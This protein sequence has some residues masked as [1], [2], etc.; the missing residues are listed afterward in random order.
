[1]KSLAR[2]LFE[3]QL[4]QVSDDSVTVATE[5]TSDSVPEVDPSMVALAE[6]LVDMSASGLLGDLKEAI[7]DVKSGAYQTSMAAKVA[8]G[9]F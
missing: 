7:M 1:M 5:A 8:A 9:T 2:D 6:E 4:A 3:L